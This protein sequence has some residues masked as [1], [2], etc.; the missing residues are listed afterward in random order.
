[1]PKGGRP[2]GRASQ[3]ERDVALTHASFFTGAGGMDIGL[4]RAGWR[5]VSFSE[6]DRYAC[7]LLAYRWPHVPQLGDVSAISE[8]P[9]ARLWTAGFPCQDLSTLGKQSGIT[10]SRSGYVWDFL[11]L[12]ARDRPE[13]VLF[14]NVPGL[15]TSNMG[16]DFGVFAHTLA[17]LRYVGAYRTFD[18]AFFGVPQR[19]RRVF[20][21]ALDAQRHPDER[22]SAE[23]L[24]VGEACRRPHTQGVVSEEEAPG[25]PGGRAGIVPQAVRAKWASR[26]SGPPG[27]EHHNLVVV[28]STTL[29]SDGVRA[30]TGVARRP[31]LGAWV[32]DRE[33]NAHEVQGGE[34]ATWSELMPRELDNRRYKVI[35]NG[36]SAPVATYIGSRLATYLAQ[37]DAR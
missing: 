21:L 12:V 8:V 26:S 29:A 17:E 15:L 31:Y 30:V 2:Q 36:V 13:C 35:G 16:R 24:G 22:S 6:I 11:D 37:H 7:H 32:Q 4:E 10:G 28:G 14:E 20:V 34:A 23:V 33:G 9:S 3:H 25:A 27:T 5:T 19:R 18:S 1:M